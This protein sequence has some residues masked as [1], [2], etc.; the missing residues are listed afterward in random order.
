LKPHPPILLPL[1]EQSLLV[2]TTA[3]RLGA[4]IRAMDGPPT[5]GRD[6][7]ERIL[8]HLRAAE[9]ARA[10]RGRFWLSRP[11]LAAGVALLI[12][13]VG[14]GAHAGMSWMQRRGILGGESRPA[15]DAV[16][17]TAR[18]AAAA[19]TAPRPRAE[20][21]ELTVQE[22]QEA[23]PPAAT[24]HPIE[25]PRPSRKPHAAKVVS[26][27]VEPTPPAAAAGERSPLAEEAQL[28]GTAVSK[29]RAHHDYNSALAALDA[30]DALF[31]HGVLR[32]E[33]HLARLD[34]LMAIGDSAQALRLLD[35]TE[36]GGPRAAEL[37]VVRGELRAGAGRCG[38]AI[39]DFQRAEA[40][41][42]AGAARLR[43]RALYGQASCHARRHEAAAA[44][45]DG[46]E[47]LSRF[48]DGPHAAELRRKLNTRVSADGL[49]SA[50]LPAGD[51]KDPSRVL[52]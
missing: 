2:P 26:D 20:L 10:Q 8:R 13:V 16:R 34:A 41:V 23:P 19:A 5:L 24:S 46:E 36:L 39:A 33:A 48:P 22:L 17:S 32:D 28:L 52:P 3:T 6:A 31:P 30:Y 49:R 37:L 50:A 27:G 25:A 44:A 11:L 1:R 12:V 18:V 40:M 42:A 47:Y 21:S 9:A 14:I 15:A 7:H 45:R 29:L 38:E 43:E 51:P 35:Q 4:V